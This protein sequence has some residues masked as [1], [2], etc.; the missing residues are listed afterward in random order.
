MA[1]AK[2]YVLHLMFS[3]DWF[4]FI[5]IIS[6]HAIFVHSLK[7]EIKLLQIQNVLR[8]NEII[9]VRELDYMKKSKIFV[10]YGYKILIQ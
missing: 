10:K 2:D 3:T 9:L 7:N 4:I 8:S 5:Q 6:A 1:L